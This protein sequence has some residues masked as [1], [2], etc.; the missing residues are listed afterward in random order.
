ML[1]AGVLLALILPIKP[2]LADESLEERV[3]SYWT[4]RSSNDL[5]TLYNL[6][7]AARPGGWL[8][9]DQHQRI[10]GLPVREVEIVDTKI[11]GDRAEVKLQGQVA[12]GS[13]GWVSQQLTQQW[14]KIDGTWY[15]QTPAPR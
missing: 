8:T 14:V 12:V 9:P 4:A 5:H 7:S 13:L 11:D 1:L 2:I 10:G 15:H 6:E 3:R